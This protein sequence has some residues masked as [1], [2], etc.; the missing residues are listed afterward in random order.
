MT[1]PVVDLSHEPLTMD[2]LLRHGLEQQPF[3][4]IA[5]DTFLYTD[6]S[7]D[8]VVGVLL[9]HL[10]NDDSLLLLKGETG[11][12][13]STQLLR[14]LSRGTDRLE[15]CAFKAR[16][17]TNFAA[18][19]HTIR[20]YWKRAADD[21]EALPLDELI[22]RIAKGGR[23]PVIVV[24]DAHHLNSAVL[25]QLGRLRRE[26]RRHCDITPG[27]LLVGEPYL[28][29]N[30][31][32]PVDDDTPA[33]AHIS[34]QIRPLTR[35]QTEAYLRRRL[36]AAGAVNPG[37]LS[38]EAAL[39]IY[40]ESGGLPLHINAAANRR[41]QSLIPATDDRATTGRQPGYPLAMKALL[42]NRWLVPAT[43]VILGIVA[44]AILVR[45]VASP[46]KPLETREMLVL[47]E[48]RPL[49][50]PAPAE[51][52]AEAVPSRPEI[53]FDTPAAPPEQ[54][55]AVPEADPR[56]DA[57]ADAGTPVDAPADEAVAEAAPETP[58][59]SPA[60]AARDVEPAPAP[61]PAAAPR[62][63]ASS[64]TAPD[65][66][67][68][69]LR[70]TGWLREQPAGH[71]TIQILAL[72]DLQSLRRYGR[73]QGLDMDLA[74]FRTVRDGRDW[75]VLVAGSYPDAETARVAIAGLPEPVRS[76]KPW[77]RSFG[78]IQEAMASA[79]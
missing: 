39:D 37:L 11:A 45:I 73:E 63:A 56:A 25:A 1:Q 51:E 66:D 29:I 7:L 18:V 10:R 76:N 55:V 2:C 48:P 65:A 60:E 57:D 77:V 31:E 22:C 27:L 50:A 34:V 59:P 14:L 68:P 47:P 28:E 38:G 40:Q 23:R 17:G 35:E 19:E 49:S 69:V 58:P 54:S 12:G 62:A 44:L 78:S 67:G 33:E 71:F 42:K 52:R 46:D 3:D 64:A 72:S 75:Y 53:R 5:G 4:V 32:Q 6:P 16:A 9:E 20:Q 70:D 26:V 41:L 8:M 13:K 15:F 24:D 61:P 79:R 21:D 36:Q 74:W 43:A 30:L